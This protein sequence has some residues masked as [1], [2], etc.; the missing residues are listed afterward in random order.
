[1]AID[2]VVLI[3]DLFFLAVPL[4]SFYIKREGVIMKVPELVTIVDL[5]GLFL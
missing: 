1:V 3:V 2:V 4:P 5:I